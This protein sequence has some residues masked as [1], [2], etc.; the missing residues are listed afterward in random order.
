[1]ITLGHQIWE[2][3]RPNLVVDGKKAKDDDNDIDYLTC[4]T[5][6]IMTK[7][8]SIDIARSYVL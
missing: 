3:G 7:F 2:E 6:K 8:T 5:T 1:M 4:S